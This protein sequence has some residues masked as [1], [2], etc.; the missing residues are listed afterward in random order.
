[1]YKNEIGWCNNCNVP[2][3]DGKLCGICNT[4]SKKLNLKFKG[5]I[6]PFFPKEETF[7]KRIIFS[8]F[9]DNFL[10]ELD[11]NS[12]LFFN[13]TSRTEYR[14]DI[15]IDGKTLF[16][17]IHNSEKKGWEIKPYKEA[18]NFF[19]PEKR[20]LIIPQFLSPT[21][22]ESQGIYSSW[23]SKVL[24]PANED[25]FVIIESG[26]VKA[27]GKVINKSLRSKKGKR[28]IDVIDSVYINNNKSRL[29][30]SYLNDVIQANSY[31]LEE[32]ENQA[33]NK[34]IKAIKKLNLPLI[35]SF[36]GGKDSSVVADICLNIESSIDLVFFDTGIEFPET[37][38]FLKHFSNELHLNDNLKII[39][40]NYDFFEL[41]NIFGPPSRSQRWCCK[42]QKFMPMNNFILENYKSGVLSALANR[43]NESLRRSKNKNFIDKNQWIPEQSIVYPIEDWGL[44]D[45]W[46]YIFWK[47]LPYNKLY[48]LG[49]PRVGCWP[50]PF[51]SQCIFNIMEETHS[52]LIQN[53]NNHL[54]KWAIKHGYDKNWVLSGDWR[55]RNGTKTKEQV[56]YSHACHEGKPMI[57]LVLDSNYGEKVI[58]ML[59]IL[60]NEY[61]FHD[62]K[63]KNVVCIPNNISMKKLK[64]LL[65]KASNCQMCGLCVDL[66]PQKALNL[67]NKGLYVEKLNCINCFKCLETN[68]MSAMYNLKENIIII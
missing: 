14:G 46:L 57:H 66:C 35:V 32:K 24:F 62:E 33:R 59:P 17:I 20:L 18:L 27:I 58:Q 26:N 50:C 31:I 19:K 67:N 49:I 10:S 37:Y 56:G 3:L 2:I 34:I 38:E 52:N 55:L 4:Q 64:I 1:M 44:L 15:I 28:V 60:T 8:Y 23:I 45:V 53:L 13:E 22:R 9:S 51:Q 11:K 63:E 36:S 29:K 6:R 48:E 30:G 21:L 61:E 54:N 7:I 65:E 12:I 40:S 41:W 16:Q 39:K 42:T 68:C 47:K 5:E 25:D 43:K